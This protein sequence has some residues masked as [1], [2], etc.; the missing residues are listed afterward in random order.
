MSVIV[1]LFATALLYAQPDTTAPK[2][3]DSDRSPE[4]PSE[5][6]EDNIIFLKDSDG[7]LIPV[8]R[9]SLEEFLEGQKLLKRNQEPQV[10]VPPYSVTEV[11][12]TGKANDHRAELTAR[13]RLQIN[14]DAG[15]VH[16]PLRLDEA[17]LRDPPQY[18]FLS[19]FPKG[20]DTET[21]P[22]GEAVYDAEGSDA[23]SGYHW[24]FRGVGQHELTIPL[25][26]TVKK[27]VPGRRIQLAIPPTAVSSLKLTVP[28]QNVTTRAAP[29]TTLKTESLSNKSTQ[30]ELIGL[31][32]LLEL[33][34]QAVPRL[35]PSDTDLQATTNMVVNVGDDAVE[36]DA[37][38]N[39]QANVGSFDKVTVLL[40]VGFEQIEL[41]VDGNPPFMAVSDI[42][43]AGKQFPGKTQEKVTVTFPQPIS[44]PVT[45]KWKL[46][47]TS[48]DKKNLILNG[49][50]VENA[51]RQAG[52]IRVQLPQ[53]YRITGNPSANRY[54]HR[55]DV[56]G[57]IPS[58]K[59]VESYR[60]LKQPFE[61][62]LNIS[63]TEP[64]FIVHPHQFLYFTE[65][66][67]RLEYVVECNVFRG[68]LKSIR[69]NWP[70]GDGWKIALAEF[71]RAETRTE[72]TTTRKGDELLVEFGERKSGRFSIEIIASRPLTTGEQNSLQLPS[73]NAPSRRPT[74]LVS[75][76]ADNVETVLTP[77]EQ[78]ISRSL[79]Q[80]QIVELDIPRQYRKLRR[81]L[82]QVESDRHE[83]DVN[84]TAHEQSVRSKA[85]VFVTPTLNQLTVSQ[86]IAFD[87]KYE[88]LSEVHLM[89][90]SAL[91][92]KVSFLLDDDTQLQPVWTGD[93][94]GSLRQ[95]RLA[96]PEPRIGMAE[97][98][99]MFSITLE[100]ETTSKPG[101]Q[102]DLPYIQSLEP[103]YD[104]LD[105]EVLVVDDVRLAI[106]DSTWQKQATR[107]QSELWTATE[108]V[109]NIPI[110]FTIRNEIPEDTFV[111]RQALIEAAFD[112][113]GHCQ[114]RAM[115]RV[116]GDVSVLVLK[117]PKQIEPEQLWWNETP[118]TTDRVRQVA[119]GT[120]QHEYH[121]QLFEAPRAVNQLLSVDY[122]TQ[123]PVEVHWRAAH[124]VHI[125]TLIGGIWTDQTILR[126]SLPESHHLFT[127][128]EGMTPQ[129]RW[130]RNYLLWRRVTHDE[131]RDTGSWIGASDGPPPRIELYQGSSYQ[132]GTFGQVE[133][134]QFTSLQRNV[135]FFVGAA[136]A[137]AI[138]VVIIKVPVLR[139]V[140]T[141]L[142]LALVGA[143]LSLWFA[144][145][146]EL[147]I[148]PAVCGLIFALGL[149]LIERT[150]RRRR[151]ASVL[152]LSTSSDYFTPSTD[153]VPTN[154]GELEIE[155]RSATS[156]RVTKSASS[157]SFTKPGQ[158]S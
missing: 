12:L 134:L 17:V 75:A 47:L 32:N 15:W 55:A 148:Q 73:V 42:Q 26:V 113:R 20:E 106:Q 91:V 45:L 115:F 133:T 87:V 137:W 11:A 79:P 99:A 59:Y 139:N 151:S 65:N 51:R 100:E 4:T 126:V 54:V 83:F 121:I 103:K 43:D 135:V 5:K 2:T 40:P 25:Y 122:H 27:Q 37:E 14:S 81:T 44:G 1:V 46:L 147:L 118:L 24:W 64:H 36:L 8:Q 125:P 48:A 53:G 61:L 152:T 85:K 9:P 28:Y 74:I 105:V 107:D 94:S 49:F 6:S 98:T 154:S 69:L 101:E 33:T 70:G 97:I 136:I 144:T 19:G 56:R 95:A 66:A 39:L 158:T 111:V 77:H 129:Y 149:V 21:K 72:T 62:P 84:I 13:I 114:A 93:D 76:N 120:D 131:H 153:A 104:K 63:E 68:A 124:T 71:Q 35:K 119:S 38:Q 60:F 116:E 142:T 156:Q 140:M 112:D 57:A 109:E 89:V 128:P 82:M 90:P 7:R 50:R 86:R 30:I 52:E 16:V 110:A 58:D 34:W 92:E 123:E 141:I 23:K 132:F 96:F 10:Q 18:R 31:G 146:I 78:T 127:Q 138:G 130:K 80:D 88:R 157:V 117:F 155:P 150:I 145:P 29:R 108:L 3:P 67:V 143:L 102:Y 41:L 22:K